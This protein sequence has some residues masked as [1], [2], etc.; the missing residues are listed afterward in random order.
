MKKFLLTSLALL[1]TASISAPA[2]AQEEESEYVTAKNVALKN[3]NVKNE[4]N[5]RLEVEKLQKVIDKAVEV[6]SDEQ[7]LYASESISKKNFVDEPVTINYIFNDEN[8]EYF[9]E[10]TNTSKDLWVTERTKNFFNNELTSNSIEKRAQVDTITSG[11]EPQEQIVPNTSGFEQ[12]VQA[13]PISGGIGGRVTVAST[14]GNLFESKWKL[15]S[16]AELSGAPSE[17]TYIYTGLSSSKAEV[18]ANVSLN[19]GG[20]GP[21]WRPRLC[22]KP[23]SGN[24]TCLEGVRQ[25]GYDKVHTSNGYVPGTTITTAFW[26]AYNDSTRGISNAVRLKT[27]G[28]A[29][30]ADAGCYN[31]ND[32]N[33]INILEVNNQNITVMNYFKLLATIAGNDATITGNVRSTFSNITLDGVAKTPVNNAA[34]YATITISGN[35][36]TIIVSK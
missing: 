9:Y 7:K 19:T 17:A 36:A 10:E 24:G 1:I 30:C 14:T 21:R 13:D 20:T 15:A 28:L 34:D 23:N 32:T 6:A 33:L 31:S 22:V 29:I 4:S 3:V 35:S 16:V 2:F 11:I 26:R 25:S 8:Y 18:D 5:L 12:Q 27:T